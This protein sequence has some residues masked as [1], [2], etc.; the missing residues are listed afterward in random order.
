MRS[1]PK[2]AI[3]LASIVTAA[4]ATAPAKAPA[5]P[6]GKRPTL[7]GC[8]SNTPSLRTTTRSAEKAAP[9]GSG[10]AA[11]RHVDAPPTQ[12]RP[13]LPLER[14]N[15]AL[16]VEEIAEL[17]ALLQKTPPKSPDRAGLVLRLANDYA[18]L[19]AMAEREH[20]LREIEADAAR[21]EMNRAEQQRA[22]SKNTDRSAKK[23]AG[24]DGPPRRPIR[25]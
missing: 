14:R 3:L 19:T 13:D 24:P 2:I 6:P 22:A 9:A 25:F 12:L 15:R 8:A 4:A 17:E 1:P 7:S 10:S 11:P 5:C 18:E 16:L 21:A 20:T 23:P